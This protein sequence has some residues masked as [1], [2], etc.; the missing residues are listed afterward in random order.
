MHVF[1]CIFI[2]TYLNNI[3]IIIIIY[4]FPLA[5]YCLLYCSVCV[6][7]DII[8]KNKENLR[9]LT[10]PA[11]LEMLSRHFDATRDS[12]VVSAPVQ[13]GQIF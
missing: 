3:M 12:D 2:L 1:K 13:V 9:W 6:V 10:E 11:A 4:F 7:L 8:K 5:L